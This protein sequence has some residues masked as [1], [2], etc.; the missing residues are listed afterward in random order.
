MR[1]PTSRHVAPHRWADAFAGK[2][3]ETELAAMERHADGCNACAKARKR[4][5]RA[6]QSFPVLKA[7]S[8]PE[9]GW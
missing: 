7:Q 4:V 8:A 5:Q 6:S 2:L 1:Q 3:S 9:L